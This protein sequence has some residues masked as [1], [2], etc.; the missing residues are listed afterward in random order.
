MDQLTEGT[1]ADIHQLMP[2][3]ATLGRGFTRVTAEA[4]PAAGA[5]FAHTFGPDFWQRVVAVS[6]TFTTSAA[7]GNR[8]PQISYTD[9]NSNLIYQMAATPAVN[10]GQAVAVAA[11][12]GQT[13]AFPASES[14]SATGNATAVTAGQAIVTLALTQGDWVI[15]WEVIF[16]GTTGAAEVDNCQLQQAGAAVANSI[17]GNSAGQQYV[18][19]AQQVQIPA[20]GAAM[21]INA[22]ANGTATA[23]YN[24][25]IVA[26]LTGSQLFNPRLPDLVMRPGWAFN[27]TAAGIQAGDQLSA[28][29]TTRERYSSTWAD[30]SLAEDGER[31]WRLLRDR[32]LGG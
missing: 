3:P 24:V 28:L 25:T 9:A 4:S 29:V 6:F 21:T 15:N 16:S 12:L 18:Q 1:L 5:G 22:I 7:A 11:D 32:L 26:T 10:G 14:A 23:R 8:Y 13:A 31:M 27:V 17:N 2:R 19:L 30:G 20:A